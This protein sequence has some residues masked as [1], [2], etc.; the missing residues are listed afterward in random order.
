[1]FSAYFP[2]TKTTFKHKL[3]FIKISSKYK[4]ISNESYLRRLSIESIKKD[5]T[6]ETNGNKNDDRHLKGLKHTLEGFILLENFKKKF[7]I[8]DLKSFDDLLNIAKEYKIKL[9]KNT[10]ESVKKVNDDIDR[11]KKEQE[12][13]L[14]EVMRKLVL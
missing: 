11:K 4:S 12:K 2:L 8:I 3:D 1:M 7:N 9:N 5:I 14:R 10:R 13:S 6:R